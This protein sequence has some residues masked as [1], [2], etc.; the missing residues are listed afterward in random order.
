MRSDTCLV[1]SVPPCSPDEGFPTQVAFYSPILSDL[2]I[3]LVYCLEVVIVAFRGKSRHL[4]ST[5]LDNSSLPGSKWYIV[6]GSVYPQLLMIGA[7][8]LTVDGG[9][10][11]VSF[12][13]DGSTLTS[14]NADQVDGFD[15]SATATANTLLA[16]DGTGKLP[17]DITGN[18]ATAATATALAGDGTGT[19]KLRQ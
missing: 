13:G 10:E 14:V 1:Q 18:A 12:T 5:T 6:S 3:N 11:A 19:V 7:T 16:L 17:A 15:V 9:V 2:M 8:E 4:S